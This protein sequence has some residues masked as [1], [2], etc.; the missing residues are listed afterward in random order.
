[1]SGR[2]WQVGWLKTRAPWATAPPFGSD[3]PYQRRAIRASEMAPAH[4]AQG[5]SVTVSPQPV[6]RS[7]PSACPPA[8]ITR[9]SAW[10][11][12]SA[13]SRT[14]L[15]ALASTLPSGAESTAPIGA[16]P[17]AAARRASSSASFIWLANMGPDL[18]RIM[19]A[20]QPCCRY[21]GAWPETKT[22]TNPRESR[23]DWRG[24]GSPRGVRPSA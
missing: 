19:L 13:S 4:I 15:P 17:L 16:S 24:Q 11:V 12:G 5:S 14:R 9:S 20:G 3:A 1:M 7:E 10:A 2:W 23:K 6:S 21:E 18:L 8:R 22:L